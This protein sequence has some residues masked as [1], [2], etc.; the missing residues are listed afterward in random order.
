LNHYLNSSQAKTYKKA[1]THTQRTT[2]TFNLVKHV[3]IRTDIQSLLG[4]TVKD[5]GFSPRLI[6]IDVKISISLFSNKP[7]ALRGK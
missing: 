5:H 2:E 3:H 6:K 4:M 7:V 1:Q